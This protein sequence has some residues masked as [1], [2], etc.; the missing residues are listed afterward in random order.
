[1]VLAGLKGAIRR[2]LLQA[3]RWPS[4][5]ALICS[6][7]AHLLGRK[8]R[9]EVCSK[10]QLKCP[11]CATARG[12]TRT[13]VVAWGELAPENLTKFLGIAGRIRSLEISNWGEIF[14]N[15]RLSALLERARD[16]GVAVTVANGVN[17]NTASDEALEALVQ[18]GVK[19]LT[20]SIDGAT[21]QSY[22]RFRING[23][24]DRVLANV[25]RINHFKR[26]H[27]TNFPE[28]TW[29]FIVFG[30]N[31]D[32]VEAAR[33]MAAAREMKFVAIRNLA[34]DYSPV[35]DVERTAART[36]LDLVTSTDTVLDSMADNLGF[37]HQ[38]WD[39]P[40]VNWNGALLG[41][42]FNNTRAFGNAFETPL[43]ELMAGTDYR[44]LQAML[45]GRAPLRA[46]MPCT[47][48]RL[49]PRAL[50]AD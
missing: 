7:E 46:D 38:V 14:L 27:A 49:L 8:V 23:T 45:V 24:L 10:C 36:G 29:Q 33:A 1:M 22:A 42:C 39:T 43:A 40:Q 15:R 12:E 35:R 6:L 31:E 34:A 32:E 5:Y 25:D 26:K 21:D 47:S 30:H 3:L 16:S 48:C 11:T 37:C 17:L 20:I 44:Y 18:S 50:R 9:L 41:C 2:V 4:A 19:A 28:L 13:G